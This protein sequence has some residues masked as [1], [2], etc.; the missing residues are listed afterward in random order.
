MDEM[1]VDHGLD[2]LSVFA[3]I[4]FFFSLN[5]FAT[6][7]G[8]INVS[9]QI[10]KSQYFLRGKI[11]E[12]PWAEMERQLGRPFTHWKIQITEQFSGNSLGASVI[13][14]QPGGEINGMGYRVAGSANFT[15]GED[16][17]VTVRE[18]DEP[19]IKEV[20]GLASGKYRVSQKNGIETVENGIGFPVQM[21]GKNLDA[22]DFSRLARKISK[23]TEN[24]EEKK[25]ILN[26]RFT[27]DHD[28]VLDAKIHQAVTEKKQ[29]D[30]KSAGLPPTETVS[31][32]TK[33]EDIHQ[34][35]P[36]NSEEHNDSGAWKF[37]VIALLAFIVG[38]IFILRRK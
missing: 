3:L 9:D 7:F 33:T 11:T 37:I 17:F 31:S 2:R 10:R 30:L 34:D 38:A 28:P 25:I 8:P 13:L 12:G 5:S 14:R 19:G 23:G 36:P 35:G 29:A 21:G 32:A 22:N 18:T 24:D 15:V 20:V 16:V 6:T 26:D 1:A 27:Q 4:L